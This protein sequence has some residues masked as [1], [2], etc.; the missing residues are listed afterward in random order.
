LEKKGRKLS[1]DPDLEKL[2]QWWADAKAHAAE[3]KP[4]VAA[5]SLHGGQT[6]LK[7]TAAVPAAM[8]VG[9]LILIV[10]FQMIGGYKPA[11][12]AEEQAADHHH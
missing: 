4:F 10:Y 11:T 5:A 1:E 8:A 2:S 3:D 9:Y 6:A 7:W 12:V